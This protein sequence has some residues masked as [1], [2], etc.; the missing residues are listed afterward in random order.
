MRKG[1]SMDIKEIAKNAR[2]NFAGKCR[3]C[4]VCN[5]VACAGQV[6][7]MGGVRTAQ[8]F[9]NNV[10]EWKKY[11]IKMTGI[12]PHEEID[13]SC[14]MFGEKLSMPIMIAPIGAV[15]VNMTEM[16]SEEEYCAAVCNGAIEV[17]TMAF[18]GDSGAPGVF[19][20][21]LTQLAPTKGR[22]IPTIKPRE[23]DTLIEYGRKALAKGARILASDMDAATLI[24]MRIFGQP[25][26]RK[27]YEQWAYIMKTL[28]VPFIIKGVMDAKVACELIKIGAQGIVISNHGGRMLDGMMSTAQVL[29]ETH[30]CCI[31][32]GIRDKVKLMVDGGIRTGEDV[33]KALALGADGVLI[34]RPA[35][36]AAVGGQKEGVITLLKTMNKA[37]KDAM[38]MNGI[39]N[40]SEIQ[41][42]MIIKI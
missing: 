10:E 42:D 2:Q 12:A 38:Y 9:K 41:K 39:S 24:H 26:E 15:N 14:E 13:T 20:G 36:I 28:Q 1:Y 29:K 21:G 8:S 19:D 23:D 16:M 11:A 7:G 32:E 33:F 4:P 37:L 34:G 22:M 35:A 3:V 40:L 5:G 6:P 30:E 27:T 17:G 31:K 25:V 18:T